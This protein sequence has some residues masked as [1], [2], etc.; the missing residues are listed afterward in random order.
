MKHEQRAMLMT[1]LLRRAVASTGVLVVAAIAV[2]P[3]ISAA[4]E[5]V[6][7]SVEPAEAPQTCVVLPVPLLEEC[8][9]GIVPGPYP[10][11]PGI[12]APGPTLPPP[13]IAVAPVTDLDPAGPELAGSPPLAGRID[14]PPAPVDPLPSAEVR[15]GQDADRTERIQATDVPAANRGPAARVAVPATVGHADTE[16]PPASSLGTTQL[17]SE[18]TAGPGQAAAGVVQL[19]EPLGRLAILPVP[20]L[21]PTAVSAAVEIGRVGGGWGAAVVFNVWLRRQLRERRMTQRQLGA[22]SGVN[23]S[24][25]SRLLTGDRTPS[26]NTATKLARALRKVGHDDDA[27]RYFDD[28]SDAAFVPTQRVE[29]ALRG[30]EDLDVQDVRELMHAYL[31]VRARRRLARQLE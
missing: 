24:T 21:W 11:P 14:P 8:V 16:A 7:S 12:P 29:A 10:Q 25:I 27:A 23:H 28:L 20:A 1:K 15:A 13:M 22:R 4:D 30:D 2:A 26:L 9:Q 31:R 6:P 5:P 3:P 17:P 18:T 19:A